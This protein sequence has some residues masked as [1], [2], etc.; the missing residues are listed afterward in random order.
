MSWNNWSRSVSAQPARLATPRS[1]DELAALVRESV[2][3]RAVGAGHSFMPLCATEGTL[4]DLAALD[5]PS[6][7]AA[8]HQSA[9]AP[10]RAFRPPVAVAEAV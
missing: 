9:W 1:E 7:L 10:K 8:D 3:V 5:L 2:K 6:E 4:L